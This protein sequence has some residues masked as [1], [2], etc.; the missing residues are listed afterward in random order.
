MTPERNKGHGEG[1]K[2]RI[3]FVIPAL[4]IKLIFKMD[5]VGSSQT[6]VRDSDWQ[7]IPQRKQAFRQPTDKWVTQKVSPTINYIMK[8]Y[9]CLK[10]VK[11][12]NR[13]TEDLA[14]N[15]IL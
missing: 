14:K 6:G 13:M 2:I 9:A 11:G 4:S 5:D 7:H 1:G 12:H 15:D 10:F 8:E 3:S